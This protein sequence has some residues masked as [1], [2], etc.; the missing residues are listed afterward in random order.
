M[1]MKNKKI[2]NLIGL[3]GVFVTSVSVCVGQNANASMVGRLAR[4]AIG[5]L[6]S[7][8][9]SLSRNSS[10]R[11]S[12]S[13]SSRASSNLPPRGATAPTVNMRLETITQRVSSLE[14]SRNIEN[15][16]SK[17]PLSKAVLVSGLVGSAAMVSGIVGSI[18][19]QAKMTE[20]ISEQS[21]VDQ[22]AQQDLNNKRQVLQDKEIPEAVQDII[23]YY[24]DHYGIE[25]TTKEN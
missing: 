10:I 7:T 22:K 17:S 12:S 15:Q 19:Q 4:P 5:S 16:K 18:I 20:L 8:A 2:I 3:F 24:K 14:Q 23:K 9:S 1:S 13:S 6:R 11:S 25:L 21:R